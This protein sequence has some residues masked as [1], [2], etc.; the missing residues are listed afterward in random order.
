MKLNNTNPATNTIVPYNTHLY[1]Y[2]GVKNQTVQ[3]TLYSF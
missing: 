2:V 3:L 1:K